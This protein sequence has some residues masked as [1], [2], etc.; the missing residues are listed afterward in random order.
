M[1]REQL[2]RL[3]AQTKKQAREEVA[4]R[5]IF[6][7][8]IDTESILELYKLAEKRRK[9]VGAMV[10]EWVLE[11][12]GHEKGGGSHTA[13]QS[14]LAELSRIKE[15]LSS[16]EKRLRDSGAQERPKRQGRS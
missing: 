10:R 3:K 5:E 4:K 2:E 14:D 6:H 1:M 15:R 12:L 11:R 8:R 16:L 7:F 9:P 13:R